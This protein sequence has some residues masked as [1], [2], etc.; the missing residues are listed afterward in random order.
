[1]VEFYIEKTFRSNHKKKGAAN[2]PPYV[3]VHFE[4]S[5]EHPQRYTNLGGSQGA[6]KEPPP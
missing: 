5:D 6:R 3:R 4:H 1:M 2:W